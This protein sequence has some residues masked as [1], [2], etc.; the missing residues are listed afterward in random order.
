VKTDTIKKL[1]AMS[2]TDI[3]F[4][5]DLMLE[6]ELEYVWSN[7]CSRSDLVDFSDTTKRIPSAV[8]TSYLDHLISVYRAYPTFR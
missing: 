5:V 3:E 7:S 1:V 6:K 4:F 8:W 2:S